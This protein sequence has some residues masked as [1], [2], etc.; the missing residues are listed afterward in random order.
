MKIERMI[1]ICGILIFTIMGVLTYDGIVLYKRSQVTLS[2]APILTST[3][4][5]S[6]TGRTFTV[7]GVYRSEDM[8]QAMVVIS[9]DLSAVSYI[10][11]TYQVYLI[12]PSAAKFSGG[13]YVFGDLDKLCVYVTNMDGFEAET[14]EVLLKST[15]STGTSTRNQTDD[16]SFVVNLGASGAQT[17]SFMSSAGLDIERMTNSAFAYNDD[18]NIRTTLET[19]QSTMVSAR[20]QLSNVRQ[21]LDKAGIQLPAF[22][23]WMPDDTIATREGVATEYIQTSYVFDGAADFDWENVTRLDNY[24]ELAG[25]SVDMLNRESDDSESDRPYAKDDVPLEWYRDDNSIITNPTKSE[26]ALMNQYG[27]AL[28]AYYDSKVAYQDEVAKLIITQD[29]YLT[30]MRTYTSNVG[31]DAIVGVTRK[32]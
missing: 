16:M 7:D 32:K 5:T 24:A 3:S 21:N 15:A 29:D 4:I 12:G 26:Q 20:A 11:D 13:L 18:S 31:G 8:T 28:M 10:A 22:P 27:T 9:G 1:L 2:D 17:V 30:S 19:L 25:V 23:E 6:L 14:T